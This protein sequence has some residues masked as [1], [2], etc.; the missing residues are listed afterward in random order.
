MQ[1]QVLKTAI[2]GGK[3]IHLID[4]NARY[5]LSVS[6]RQAAGGL[7]LRQELYSLW[8]VNTAE[9]QCTTGGNGNT[10]VLLLDTL[11]GAGRREESSLYDI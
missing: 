9:G 10:Y 1:H 11:P 3:A 4:M 2:I 8:P 7:V 5:V 6:S